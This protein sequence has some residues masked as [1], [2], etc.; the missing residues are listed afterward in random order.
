M[1]TLLY[2][3]TIDFDFALQQRPHHL[4]NLLSKTNKYKVYWVNQSKTNNKGKTIINDNLEVYH[5][6]D[7]FVKRVPEVDIYFSS[8]AERYKDLD[9]VK[10]K[11]VL[12]DSLDNFEVNSYNESDMLKH[13]QIVLTASKPLYE[14]R[15]SEHSNVSLCRNGCFP[16]LGYTN[17][18]EPIE[19]K[20]L[21]Q[22]GKPILLFSGA[23]AYWCDLDIV[24]A[25]TIR[26]NVVVVGL[27]WGI[28]TKPTN[29]TY[30]GKKSYQELQAYYSH[31]DVNLLPFKRCQISD[32]SNPIKMFEGMSHG[33]I[34]VSTDIPEACDSEYSD[35]VLTSSNKAEFIQ[36]IEK[37][38]LIKDDENII[39]KC[40]DV[41]KNNS[42]RN[43]IIH[44]D[45]LI[46]NYFEEN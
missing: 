2:A 35:I 29:C 7:V 21:R 42:W 4:M 5:H 27:P 3:N 43:R 24:Q 1:R 26:Y 41:A 16:E 9:R 31:C 13:S 38:L 37:A 14:L 32:Y 10:A 46:K 19:Y 11:L 15:K 39:S 28:T 44:I 6:W 33:K 45:S 8:W 12:Y 36:N 30:V 18:D 22:N 25:L 34:T 23:L 20:T 40:Y 17:Y